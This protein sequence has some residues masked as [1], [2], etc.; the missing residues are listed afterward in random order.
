M[1]TK[2]LRSDSD[3]KDAATKLDRRGSATIMSSHAALST[4]HCCR[5]GGQGVMRPMPGQAPT[6]Y[7]LPEMIELQLHLT[8]AKPT[9]SVPY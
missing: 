6:P 5:A 7:T 4:R 8:L 2:K 3:L 1:C 9:E